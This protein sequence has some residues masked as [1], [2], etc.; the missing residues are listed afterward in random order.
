MTKEVK[1]DPKAPWTNAN[2]LKS[3][4]SADSIKNLRNTEA[5]EAG[6]NTLVAAR[7]T[8]HSPAKQIPLEEIK[9]IIVQAVL[10]QKA[11]E[12]AKENGKSR[13]DEWK[14]APDSAQLQSPLVLSREQ[15]MNLPGNMVD[16][17]MR[18]NTAKLPLLVGVDLGSRGYGIVKINK[19]TKELLMY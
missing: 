15:N 16:E 9:P 14:K 11:L 5:I 7:I 6:P 10:V 18:A 19:R 12:L 3:L 17:A 4:F 2:L 13:L 8:K 1:P